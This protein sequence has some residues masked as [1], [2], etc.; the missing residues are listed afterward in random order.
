MIRLSEEVLVFVR[1]A[2]FGLIV[3]VAY[4]F[5]AYEPAGTAL[6][7]GFGIATGAA[8]TM[9]WARSRGAGRPADGWPLGTESVAIPAPAYTPLGIGIGAGLA[10]LGVAFGPLLVVIGLIVM[11]IGARAWLAAAMR[12]SDREEH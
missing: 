5:L 10:A 6:L 8:A 9:L 2:S 4:W 11:I 7:I 3:G 12:E 1:L